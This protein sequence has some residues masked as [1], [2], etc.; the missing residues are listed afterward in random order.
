[1]RRAEGQEGCA[2][3]L[4]GRGGEGG[5]ILGSWG[6]ADGSKSGEGNVDSTWILLETLR[7]LVLAEQGTSSSARG[8]ASEDCCG[9]GDGPAATASLRAV[10]GGKCPAAGK[11]GWDWIG[12]EALPAPSASGGLGMKRG[13]VRRRFLNQPPP[14]SWANTDD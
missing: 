6:W 7:L 12:A 10:S 14:S 11:L 1:M 8:R 13:A 3:H 9:P 4:V 2:G 5:I